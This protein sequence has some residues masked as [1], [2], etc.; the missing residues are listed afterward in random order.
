M[1]FDN[2]RKELKCKI[3]PLNTLKDYKFVVVCS[4]YKGKWVFSKHKQRDTWETQGGHIEKDEQPLDSA[5]RELFEESGIIDAILY[6]VCDYDGYTLESSSTGVVYLAVVN[7][8]GSFPESE[9]EKIDFFDDIPNN[10]TYPNVTP[11]LVKEA[12]KVL[13]YLNKK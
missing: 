6:P 2:F 12:E 1:D 8:I 13:T 9:M 5:K 4:N 11:L 10:F 7:S 3:F